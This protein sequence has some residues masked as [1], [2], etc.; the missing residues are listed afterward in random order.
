MRDP[1]ILWAY[2][3]FVPGNPIENYVLAKVLKS[4]SP[5]FK[6][7]DIVRGLLP[8]QEYT[9]ASADVAKALE[10]VEVREGIPMEMYLGALG[11]PGLSAYSSFYGIGKP[12]SGET[13]FISSAAGAVGQL[14]GQL[15]KREGL[16]VTGSVGTEEKREYIVNE[17]GFDGAFNYKGEHAG[18]ALGRLAPQGLD[19]YYDN[20][21]GEQLEAA[22]GRMRVFGRVG[23]SSFS[24]FFRSWQCV[25]CGLTETW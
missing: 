23:E 5:N 13:I 25:W 15:A 1:S 20:V 8:V 2:S 17:L 16:A 7:G 22:L 6:E 18:E 9:F 21:G 4:S 12:K 19:L 10:V 3:A 24:A 14:V 11:M